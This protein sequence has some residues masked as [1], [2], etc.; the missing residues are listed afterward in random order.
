MQAKRRADEAAKGSGQ[1]RLT[2]TIAPRQPNGRVMLGL[3][4]I[5]GLFDKSK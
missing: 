2:G 3:A 1:A 4:F 5:A